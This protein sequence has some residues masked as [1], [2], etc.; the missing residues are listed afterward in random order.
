L[1]NRVAIIISLMSLGFSFL[2]IPLSPVL[3]QV[4][5]NIYLLNPQPGGIVGQEVTLQ[6]TIG[7]Q[8]GAYEV[9]FGDNLLVSK[10]SEGYNVNAN[11]TIP[12][13]PEGS[14][15]II[16]RDVNKNV[17]ATSP[18]EVEL[19]YSIEAYE[20][21]LPEQLQEGSTV[22]LNVTITGVRSDTSYYA[23]VTVELPRSLNMT[24]SYVAQLA[25]STQSATAT[26]NITYPTTAFQPL[27][28]NTS[29]TGTYNVYLNK[30]L[31]LAQDDFFVGFTD[32][33]E[34]HRGQTTNIRA[35]G[36]QP[37][38]TATISI[39][40]VQTGVEVHSETVTASSEG[41]INSIWTVP[42]DAVIGEYNVTITP[43]NEVKILTDSQLF[44]VPGFP[45]TI[46]NHNLAGDSVPQIMIEALDEA[47]NIV[48][49]GTSGDNGIATLSLERGSHTITAFWND[50]E[51]GK[52]DAT[53]DGAASFD[54][55]CELAN[56]KITVQS[57]KGDLIPFV[58]LYITYEYITSKEGLSKTGSSAVQA[59]LSA[60]F[61]LRSVLPGISY[62]VNASLYGIVFNAENNT[63]A[64]LPVQAVY[65]LTILCPSRTL[66]LS[67]IDYNRAAI[68]RARIELVESTSGI[69][70]GGVTN[71]TGKLALKVT[72]GRYRLRVYTE[73]DILLNETIVEVYNDKNIEIRC[74]LY[75]IQVSVVVVD[76]FDNPIPNVSVM[77]QSVGIETASNS[78]QTDGTVSFRNIIG[79]NIH[80]IAY[81]KGMERSYEAFNLQIE[82]PTVLKIKMDKYVVLGPFLLGANELAS[83]LL[84]LFSVILFALLELLI[85]RGKRSAER[86]LST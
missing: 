49:N 42:S 3:G 60:T 37:N 83:F 53:I 52:T 86:R 68:P 59:D 45:V 69:F 40:Y 29:Y 16:L 65:N 38:D 78:T 54:L 50:V 36:Y 30:T 1:K 28:S 11:F 47:T 79:G 18:F 48:Y 20:P 26:A 62:I 74:N 58:N 23:N 63:I 71:T 21:L 76:Y 2:L 46:H 39:K 10:K 82:E 55:R 64:N 15:T 33:S 70:D 31:L 84:I 67:V 41:I 8:N 43:Q 19:F 56:I 73:N 61:I 32:L 66:T 17:N 72:F 7:T 6:G 85:K 35:I 9:W 77:F 81:P 12:P 27:G 57:E 51:V 44:K 75:N 80:L 22:V 24:F 34:Y 14:Y 25:I 13:V 5:V 4:G